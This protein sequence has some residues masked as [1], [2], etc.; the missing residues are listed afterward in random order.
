ME[1]IYDIR[2][3]K[4]LY[5]I[6]DEK[7]SANRMSFDEKRKIAILVYIYY[8]DSA[9]KFLEYLQTIPDDIDVYI[10]SSNSDIREIYDAY[11]KQ[12]GNTYFV[13]KEN[14]GRDVSALL[15]TAREIFLQYTYICFVHDKKEKSEYLLEDTSLWIENMWDNT[16]KSDAYI[17]NV[18]GVFEENTNIGLLAVPE[19]MGTYILADSYNSWKKN[20]ENTKALAEK[21]KLK[22]DIDRGK[23]P[24]TLSTAFWCRTEALKRLF[25]I[26]WSYEDFPEEPLAKD[27]TISHA[28]ERILGYVAQDKGYDTGTVMTISYAG[29]YMAFLQNGLQQTF[30]NLRNLAGIASMEELSCFEKNRKRISEFFEKNEKIY[31]YGAGVRGKDGINFCRSMGYIPKGI[32]VTEK[33]GMSR[34]YMGIPVVSLEEI[35][36]SSDNIGIIITVGHKLRDVIAGKLQEKG[37]TNFICF[38]VSCENCKNKCIN[39]Y[40]SA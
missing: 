19:P 29:K 9:P 16:I 8:Q 10:I 36:A 12:R 25:E 37:I 31:L 21:L 1:N 26:E 32:I 38:I 39:S 18:I 24:I 27:G 7:V 40:I 22:C 33:D 6:L 11:I 4:G 2:N 15:V 35:D 13:L 23:T 20:F 3:R 17:E 28:V 14:R 30:M 34:E 5:Y